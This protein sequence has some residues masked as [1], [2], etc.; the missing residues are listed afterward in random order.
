MS[1]VTKP[2]HIQEP[3]GS[4][5][6]PI[7]TVSFPTHDAMVSLPRTIITHTPNTTQ[8][9][10]V[11]LGAYDD[12]LIDRAKG[13]IFECLKDQD[14]TGHDHALPPGM[15]NLISLGCRNSYGA[16][17]RVF[18]GRDPIQHSS[19]SN[20]CYL[21]YP[22]S[23]AL[24]FSVAEVFELEESV[25]TMAF[26]TRGVPL[27]VGVISDGFH[28]SLKPGWIPCEFLGV[29]PR[30]VVPVFIFHPNVFRHLGLCGRNPLQTKSISILRLA[31][32]FLG[33]QESEIT[34]GRTQRYEGILT[35]PKS[36]ARGMTP[37]SNTYS[38]QSFVIFSILSGSWSARSWISP[39]SFAKL[40]SCHLSG[41][42]GLGTDNKVSLENK[43]WDLNSSAT[44]Q[45][46]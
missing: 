24:L 16:L 3:Q 31:F 35:L 10:L 5:P 7:I 14:A 18:L 17:P 30:S 34:R 11:A 43:F 2:Q 26:I 22:T 42:L 19:F 39:G 41:P 13:S 9:L 15:D 29:V 36:G 37:V 33:L 23:I 20:D 1:A 27:S 8:K 38:S 32:T 40:Y 25:A 45:A 46:A 44:R 21:H 4:I 6:T 28:H 12:L